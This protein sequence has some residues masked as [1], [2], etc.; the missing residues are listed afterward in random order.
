[1]KSGCLFLSL[2]VSGLLPSGLAAQDS[3]PAKQASR[4][5][6]NVILILADDLGYGDVHAN[7]PGSRL[8]T[9]ALDALAASGMRF[10]DAHTPSS[11]CTPTRYGLLTGRYCWRSRLK[12][13]VLN[14][15][16]PPLIEADRQTMGDLFSGSGARTAIVGKWHLGLGWVREGKEIDYSKPVTHGPMQ[17]GFDES[18]IIPASLDFPPY[19]Y[20]ADGRVTDTTM[21]VQKPGRFPAF[22]RKGPRSKDLVMADVLDRLTER[23][24][25]FIRANA[26][27]KQRFFLY[28][29]LTAPHK[30][31][32]PHQR[33]RGK[34]GLG[35]YGDFV[36]QVD[37]C[38]GR[39][40]SAVDEAGITKDTM[41]VVSSDNGS[42]MY[43][44]PPDKKPDHV[45]SSRIAGYR[46]EHHRP[47][48]IYRGT[49]ADIWDAG[50][51]VPLIVRWPGH[52]PAGQ[53]EPRIVCLTDLMATFAELLGEPIAEGMAQDSVSFLP[54]LLGKSQPA[55]PALVHHSVAGMFAIRQGRYKLIAGNGSGGRERPKGKPFARPYRLSDME[56]DPEE[57]RDH[58]SEHPE[59][60]HELERLLDSSRGSRQPQ[61]TPRKSP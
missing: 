12:R 41:I 13:G 21:V 60:A 35:D 57:A 44:L 45:E 29:P 7:N 36:L 34:S 56:A 39:I 48:G 2:F 11:V 43:R 10:T 33:F 6:P 19:V 22:L 40:L 49:K 30:P 16:S 24:L 17:L 28:F 20:L 3:R 46:V 9:K 52:V 14:G 47:N 51:R 27:K 50:H 5:R 31:L 61:K 23:S 53:V 1:M 54:T 25:G 59:V 4:I 58:L 32:L 42:Y 18:L 38:V 8:R 55:R 26:A 15:Y 37:D